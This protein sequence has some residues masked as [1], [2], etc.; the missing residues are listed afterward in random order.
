MVK[1]SDDVIEG[2]NI[3]TGLNERRQESNRALDRTGDN[4]ET[5]SVKV[6]GNERDGTEEI[7]ARIEE[8]RSD[9][10][11]TIDAIQERLSFANISEQVSEQVSNAIETAK[12]T[13]YDATLGKVANF[14]KNTGNGISNSTIVKTVAEN[15]LPF[16]LIGVGAGLLAYQGFG[17]TRQSGYRGTETSGYPSYGG[18]EDQR[19]E[20]GLS[21]GSAKKGIQSVRDT[22]SNAAETAYEGISRTAETTYTAAG[23]L[24]TRAKETAGSLGNRAHETY[25]RYLEEKPWAIGV[26]AL[27]AGAAIGIA[28]PSTRYEGELMGEARVK[29]LDKV[30][31]A[32]EGFVDR[33]KQAANEVGRNLGDEAKALAEDAIG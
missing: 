21:I 24:A 6:A 17:R 19:S 29:L 31:D 13:V 2:G 22:V 20:Q 11:E 15:P 4:R 14:M 7:K 5:A 23:D 10:G 16:V 32:T 1:R 25:D 26:L 12:D 18:Y 28:I 30:Q 8:T 9:M 3:E 27:A 33:A